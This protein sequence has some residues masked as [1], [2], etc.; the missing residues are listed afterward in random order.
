VAVVEESVR[1]TMSRAAVL[2]LGASALAALPVALR[3]SSRGG[4]VVDGLLVGAA[5]LLPA[6]TLCLGLFRPAGRGLRS[7]LGPDVVRASVLRLSLFVVVALPLLAAL[8][9]VLKSVTHHRGLGGATFGV[10]GLAILLGSA[11]VSHRVAGVGE[12]LGA[13][14]GPAASADGEL[15]AR[16]GLAKSRVPALVAGLGVLL[17]VALL[18]PLVRS[19]EGSAA[20]GLR[21]ALVDGVVAIVAMLVFSQVE[22]GSLAAHVERWGIF[23]AGL[24]LLGAGLRVETAPAA[25]RAVTES[26]GLAGG[27]LGALER[28]TDRDGDGRGSHFGGGDCDDGDPLRRP[29]LV[30]VP[31]DGVDQ[32][33]DSI[34]APGA[35]QPMLAA[36]APS[37]APSLAPT[38]EPSGA[39]KAQGPATRPSIVLVTLDTVRADHTSAFGYDKPTTPVLEKLAEQG[40]SFP[41]A[42]A[43]GVDPQ[44][45]LSPL[46]TGVRWG[47][48]KRGRGAWPS[49]ADEPELVA[50]R[51]VAAGYQTGA[52]S[53][54]T[55]VSRE[56]RFDQGFVRFEEIFKEEHPE[57]GV[58]GPLAVRSASAL[59]EQLGGGKEPFFLWVHL[60]D[61]HEQYVSHG[62]PSF[63]R[64]KVGAYDGELAFVDKQLGALVEAV[65]KG[66]KAADT[67]LVVH[68]SHGEAFGEHEEKGHGAGVHEETARVPLVVVPPPSDASA[69]RKAKHE[70]V[71]SVLDLA[72]TVLALA[73]AKSDG[74]DG[75]S[76]LAALRGG[77]AL[78]RPPVLVEASKRTALIDGSL[79]L[80]VMERKGK[81][82]TLLFDLAADPKETR[83]VSGERAA[84]HKR[85]L[86]LLEASRE[87][88]P[89][90]R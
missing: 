64:G 3:A 23:V 12:H 55:W 54:F 42:Y 86:D 41:R 65:R 84:D 57:R 39:P 4:S 71:V 24:V 76:L 17:L 18:G 82:R 27:V 7:V 67:W 89:G 73:G 36:G 81:A 21:A 80:M 66:P 38:A 33:C 26:G 43:A 5:A 78:V 69:R 87:P 74:L 85:L 49:L 25:G 31:G 50:E 61:A 60:F 44:R 51:L 6:L 52:V 47:K 83:D 13:R 90:A 88:Q 2:G 63:G 75:T 22:L 14:L 40:V 59:L 68:G 32:D 34:D 37:A 56:K 46:F 70:G 20:P 29:G 62:G 77:G 8:A 11:L 35:A 16:A 30:D 19:G 48:A 45:G 1:A 9:G 58:T 79:K 10:F 28:W 15:D 72:P 53:S